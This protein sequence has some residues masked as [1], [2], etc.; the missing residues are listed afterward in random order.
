MSSKESYIQV[1]QIRHL[2]RLSD[3]R[4]ACRADAV[5]TVCYTYDAILLT[6]TEFIATNSGSRVS[7]ARGILLQVKSFRFLLCLITFDQVLSIT[8]HLS[9]VLQSSNLDLAKAINLIV[10]TKEAVQELQRRPQLTS[11]NN[12]VERLP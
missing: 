1:K 10:A 8:K 11:L 5:A 4:W 3:T 6:L 7:E 9:D 2:Q 12:A